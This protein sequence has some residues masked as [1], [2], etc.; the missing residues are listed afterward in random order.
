MKHLRALLIL[1][2]CGMGCVHL[3]TPKKDARQPAPLTKNPPAPEVTAGQV[4]NENAHDVSR[5]L[6]DE[7]D[8]QTEEEAVR[9]NAA[10]APA[11]K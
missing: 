2:A 7:M 11:K 3:G 5:S 10:K 8:R 4:T 9:E 6:W 1:A